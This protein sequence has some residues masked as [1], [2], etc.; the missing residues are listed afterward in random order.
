MRV[1]F[2]VE[3]SFEKLTLLQLSQGV[4]GGSSCVYS[5]AGAATA[6]RPL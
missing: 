1:R 4:N 3:K 5:V 2:I 6:Q